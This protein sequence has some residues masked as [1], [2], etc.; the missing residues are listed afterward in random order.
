M[1]RHCKRW[2]EE[3]LERPSDSPRKTF[4]IINWTPIAEIPHLEFR[5]WFSLFLRG[6]VATRE[7]GHA[8]RKD[9][10]LVTRLTRDR[11]EHAVFLHM[12]ASKFSKFHG[13]LQWA[14]NKDSRHSPTMPCWAGMLLFSNMRHH[15]YNLAGLA[16]KSSNVSNHRAHLSIMSDVPWDGRWYFIDFPFWT[17]HIIW[18]RVL[19]RWKYADQLA[20]KI[21]R[22][23]SP[24]HLWNS[25]LII[26][27]YA[28]PHLSVELNIRF[29]SQ[30]TTQLNSAP[31]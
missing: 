16:A 22:W 3:Q 21:S 18:W 28:S 20:G 26:A 24:V 10:Q 11:R 25:A 4:K 1:E 27:S 9:Q 5:E 6:I 19:L 23:G 30:S 31:W 15:V 2:L 17:R 13:R 29:G 8:H 12:C 14:I 7:G